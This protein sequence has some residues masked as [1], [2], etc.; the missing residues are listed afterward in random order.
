MIRVPNK[1]PLNSG[2]WRTYESQYGGLSNNYFNRKIPEL[3][4]MNNKNLQVEFMN[5]RKS[6]MDKS[7][8]L[9][10]YKRSISSARANGK[11]SQVRI[12]R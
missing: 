4:H 5:V 11:N 12:I 9:Y 6:L 10:L 7:K 3:D 8:V 2:G 1:N